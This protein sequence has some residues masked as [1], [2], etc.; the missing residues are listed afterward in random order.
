MVED[1]KKKKHSKEPEENRKKPKL[2]IQILESRSKIV[3]IERIPDTKIS[4]NEENAKEMSK[5][6]AFI[7]NSVH[8]HKKTRV[9]KSKEAQTLPVKDHHLPIVCICRLRIH[10]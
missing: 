8:S 4:T 2:G 7:C 6:D 1:N 5:S 3:T 10:K 9:Y